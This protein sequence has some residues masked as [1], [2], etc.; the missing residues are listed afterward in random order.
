[1]KEEAFENYQQAIQAVVPGYVPSGSFSLPRG[2]K[3]SHPYQLGVVLKE[4][5]ILLRKLYRITGQKEYLHHAHAFASYR[6]E[7]WDE[8]VQRFESHESGSTIWI[9][10]RTP[11]EDAVMA[12]YDMFQLTNDSLYLEEVFSFAERGRNNDFNE[13]ALRSRSSDKNKKIK[14]RSQLLNTTCI[15]REQF[16]KDVLDGETAYICFIPN[17]ESEM[18]RD[19]MMVITKSRFEVKEFQPALIGSLVDVLE[20]S[21]QTIS[22]EGFN[23]VAYRLYTELLSSVL[24]PLPATINRLILSTDGL[25]AKIPFEVLLTNYPGNTEHDFRQLPYLIRRYTIHYALSASHLSKVSKSTHTEKTSLSIHVP[26]FHNKSSLLFS[27]RSAK[28]LSMV[29]KGDLLS[30]TAA[31]TMAFRSSITKAG[32]I[33][34][35]THAEADLEEPGKSML[36]FSGEPQENTLLLSDVLGM[37]LSNPLTVISAC[38]TG[39]GK[40]VYAEGSKSFARAF[41]F[42]GSRSVLSTLWQVD[43]K[44]TSALIESFYKQLSLGLDKPSALRQAKLDYINGCKTSQ[45][46]NPFY[47]AGLVITGDPQSIQLQKQLP[48]RELVLIFGGLVLVGSVVFLYRRMK[49]SGIR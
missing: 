46:A 12:A 18:E 45:T 36:L 8:I 41:A 10:G 26:S 47:W 1:M 22:V 5:Y 31:T 48:V 40:S 23:L 39:K 7:V 28:A 2:L 44:A 38:E 37:K 49:K 14:E 24:K 9:W 3:S 19:F 43:D 11:F 32:V 25:Y 42:A 20:N 34:L 13:Q 29:Y 30:G 35:S 4:I 6:V 15:G 21:I 16:T 27:E 33:Q 17:K